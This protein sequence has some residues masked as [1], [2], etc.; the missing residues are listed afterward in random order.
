M[1]GPGLHQYQAMKLSQKLSPQ[2]VQYL[3]MLQLPTQALEQAIK[4]EIVLNPL[5][6]EGYDE[7][8]EQA[9]TQE[10]PAKEEA[11]EPE[12]E[13]D[14]YDLDDFLSDELEG[15]KVPSVSNDNEERDEIPIPET[16]TLYEFVLSQ[17]F[18]LELDEEEQ[19]IGEEIIGNLDENGYLRRSLESIV[20]DLNLTAGQTTFSVEK[21]ELVLKRIQRLDP[22]GIGSRDIQECLLVQMELSATEPEIKELATRILGHYFDDFSKKHFE[23]L[24]A[25]LNVSLDRLKCVFQAIQHLNPKPGEG[26][27][28]AQQ[29]YINPDF[30][31]TQDED[32]FVIT[33]NDRNIPPLRINKA[34][35]EMMSKRKKNGVPNEAKEYI[36]E[37]FER[38]KWFISSLH[39]RRE[40]MLRV[41][42]TILD[43][44]KTFFD[45][46]EGLRPMI[47]KDIAE[48]IG[49]DISTIS[50]VVSKKAVQTDY[51]TFPLRYFFSDSIATQDGEEVSNKEVKNTLK[52]LIDSEDP[53][54]PLSDD[55]LKKI[56]NE[57][58]LNIARRTVAKYREQMQIPVARLR[59]RLT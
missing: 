47:Y 37:N 20:Q 54:K 1:V 3:R 33:L 38:A 49:M 16:V 34:Y 11:E 48:V 27:F 45:T 40:T 44:Q 13:K 17:F 50:R 25:A 30:I 42:K 52:Q 32:D 6:E 39:Q 8:L 46:G 22:P 59:R 29:N 53:L 5:L 51:G 35:R 24:A 55:K 56:L 9:E 43:K 41:M 31:V 36:R 2:Q 21:A 57:R 19:H 7:E 14:D 58:G 28:S 23:N 15:Y 4:A 12:K 26:K 10:E 18:L